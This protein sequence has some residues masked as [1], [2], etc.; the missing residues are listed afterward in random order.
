M[1]LVGLYRLVASVTDLP[2]QI[3]CFII[4]ITIATP[5]A[6]VESKMQIRVR[7]R[8]WKALQTRRFDFC[9]GSHRFPFNSSSTDSVNLVLMRPWHLLQR[10]MTLILLELGACRLSSLSD[11][12]AVQYTYIRNGQAREHEPN[13][14][15][16][17]IAMP[18]ALT[19]PKAKH[20]FG[21]Q[22]ASSLLAS[23]LLW[24]RNTFGIVRRG[25]FTAAMHSYVV[26]HSYVSPTRGWG[27]HFFIPRSR[28][29]DHLISKAVSLGCFPLKVR[30]KNL[31]PPTVQ[32]VYGHQRSKKSLCT[33]S[34]KS[35]WTPTV[36]ISLWTPTVNKRVYGHQRSKKESMDTKWKQSMSTNSTK[37]LWAPMV[38]RVYGHQQW[39]ESMGT[40]TEK[41]LWA[42]AV[43]RVYGHQHWKES[44]G[45]NG[46]KS[47]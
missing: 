38:K 11:D 30:Q 34:T 8:T 37:S 21:L 17:F 15:S 42:P 27:Y 47:L 43:K 44:M 9:S 10:L 25:Q 26:V 19:T 31:C 33:N 36:K 2:V 32:R 22:K 7:P 28:V 4:N 39:K 20:I 24:T 29:R 14:L 6:T 1:D 5:Q 23:K 13:N 35:L 12:V 3:V 46:K 45:T 16:I 40:N 41:S 18:V